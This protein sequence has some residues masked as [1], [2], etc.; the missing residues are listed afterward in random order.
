M[1]ALVVGRMLPRGLIFFV[2]S[3]DNGSDQ[4]NFCAMRL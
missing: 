3:R 2:S 1:C 4:G